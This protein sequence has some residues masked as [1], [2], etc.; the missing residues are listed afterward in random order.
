MNKT[1]FLVFIIILFV[2]V[3][4]IQVVSSETFRQLEPLDLKKTCTNENSSAC[5]NS[6][7]CNMTVKYPNN[8][9]LAQS[10]L[11]TNNNNGLFN[12]TFNDSQI[13]AL[14]DY[15]WDMFCCDSGDCGEAHGN[16]YITKDGFPLSQDKALIYL[17]MLALLIILFFTIIVY[18]GRLP[19][20]NNTS[21]DGYLLSINK[22]KYLRAVLYVLSWGILLA[23]VFISSNVSYLFLE[24]ELMGD[25]FFM[26]YRIMMVLSLPMVIIWILYI[27]YNIFQDKE[28]KNMLERGVVLQTP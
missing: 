1:K 18:A 11:M 16:F 12:I 13:S 20:S 8:T 14:G 23:I 26:F 21:E 22:L 10:N 24:S 17:G 19:S 3:F 28:V 5:S 25:V 4:T 27:F 6:A 7:V 15:S 9:F 2:M